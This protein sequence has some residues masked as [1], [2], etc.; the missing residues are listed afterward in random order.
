MEHFIALF[1]T[2]QRYKEENKR[3]KSNNQHFCMAMRKFRIAWEIKRRSSCR[4]ESRTEWKTISH[5]LRN[6]KRQPKNFSHHTKFRMVC[7]IFLCTNS[8][9]FLSSDI[10]CNFLFSPCNQPRYFFYIF[11]YILGNIFCRQGERHTNRWK[12]LNTCKFPVVRNT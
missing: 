8:V 1:Q 7:K 10:L 11:L 12:S 6:Y 2:N 4:I 5:T 3:K 9:R